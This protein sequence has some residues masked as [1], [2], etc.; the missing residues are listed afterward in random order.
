MSYNVIWKDFSFFFLPNR[1]L[2]MS[3]SRKDPYIVWKKITKGSSEALNSIYL[4]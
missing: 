2:Q 1:I 4:V 3:T